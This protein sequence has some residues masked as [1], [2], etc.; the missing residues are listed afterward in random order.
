M[1]Y[2]RREA[3]RLIQASLAAAT[4]PR[5]LLGAETSA[6]PPASMS[7]ANFQALIGTTFT[8]NEGSANPTWLT[9]AMVEDLSI[10]D[11]R[12]QTG[13]T[14]F[15]TPLVTEAFALRMNGVGVALTADSHEFQHPALG[16]ISLFV[17][18]AGDQ[19]V[20]VFN[21]LLAPLPP[22][23]QVPMRSGTKTA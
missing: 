15:A 5:C 20:A 19:Y 6:G 12:I 13:A 10:R 3:F 18:P 22:A 17:E 14:T 9:L 8:A 1:T 11:V 21:H 4:V 16:T 7:M 23:Y 2:S